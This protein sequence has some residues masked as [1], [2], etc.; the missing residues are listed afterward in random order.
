[1]KFGTQNFRLAQMF[2]RSIFRLTGWRTHII[3]PPTT[4]YVVIGAPHTSNWDFVVAL[5]LIVAEGIPMRIVGKDSLFRGPM[6]IL[7]RSVRAIPVNRREKTNF[8]DYMAQKF[9]EN[10]EFVIGMAPEG[11]RKI[12]SSWRT[13]FYYIALKAKVPIVMAYLDYGNKVCGLGP[14]L[15]PTGDI[16]ADFKIIRDFYS[17][18]KGKHPQKQGE[19]NLL[20][21]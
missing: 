15:L 3:P 5:I 8:V 7:M 6:G 20:E 18:I 21:K 1:M 19:I 10:D 2:A 9:D 4:R 14:S 16:Q 11:T 17:G 12:T 13:G